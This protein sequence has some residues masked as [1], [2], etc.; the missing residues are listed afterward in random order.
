[1]EDVKKNSLSIQQSRNSEREKALLKGLFKDNETLIIALRNLLFGFVLDSEE[2]AILKP[3]RGSAEAL[4]LLRKIFLPTLDK[5]IPVGQSVDLWMTVKLDD[6][7]RDK[8]NIK[9][10]ELLIKKLETALGTLEG[11]KE[12]VDLTPGRT[13]EELINRNTFINHVELQLGVIRSL[14][15][16]KDETEDERAIKLA[17]DSL[18]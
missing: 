15:Q 13:A 1:M 7:T 8:V 9:A 2:E 17:K 6:P 5:D 3:L 16:Q 11:G 18:K 12:R 10:R 4:K 14:A